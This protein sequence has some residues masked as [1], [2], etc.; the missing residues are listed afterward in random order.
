MLLNIISDPKRYEEIR[1][2]NGVLYHTFRAAYN[3]LG[4]LDVDDEWHEAIC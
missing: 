4:L 2:V 1:T 3:A